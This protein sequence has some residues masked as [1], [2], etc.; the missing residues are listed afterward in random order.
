M[1]IECVAIIVFILL[2]MFIFLRTKH[3]TWALATLPLIVVPLTMAVLKYVVIGM[4]EI[5]V[6]AF[7]GTLALVIAV[8][9]SAAGIG[10]FSNL[11]KFKRTTISYVCIC[12]AFN[13]A[14][15]AILINHI[16]TNAGKLEA[17]IN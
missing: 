14:L 11:L 10:A 17:F 12:N 4:L 5:K 16:L 1:A 2:F 9:I 8:G 15:A 13:I 7:G 3:K 6:T